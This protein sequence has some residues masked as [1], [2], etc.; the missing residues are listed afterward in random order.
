MKPNNKTSSDVFIDTA[1]G[2][3]AGCLG[4]SQPDQNP[5]CSLAIFL[6][7]EMDQYK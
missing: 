1:A 2:Y 3:L 6:L 7:S 5:I 4:Y